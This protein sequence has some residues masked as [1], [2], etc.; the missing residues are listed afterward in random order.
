MYL[1][2]HFT[3]LGYWDKILPKRHIVQGLR[4]DVLDWLVARQ[5]KAI[6]KYGIKDPSIKAFIIF[7]DVIGTCVAA[8]ACVC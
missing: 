8:A 6:A 1:T 3:I 5:K 7:D 4:Q 2:T